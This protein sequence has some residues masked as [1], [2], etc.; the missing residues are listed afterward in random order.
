MCFNQSHFDQI[1]CCPTFV[2]SLKLG[3]CSE[4]V[5]LLIT[6]VNY[7]PLFDELRVNRQLTSQSC[8]IFCIHSTTSFLIRRMLE[9]V[10]VIADHLK[11]VML[12][13]HVILLDVIKF[14][15][16]SLRLFTTVEEFV[17]LSIVEVVIKKSFDLIAYL[18]HYS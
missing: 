12:T 5:F 14:M 17:L 11:V 6:G 3:C 9:D 7:S 2:I 1:F 4:L 13:M 10:V 15:K 8:I 18:S 16:F